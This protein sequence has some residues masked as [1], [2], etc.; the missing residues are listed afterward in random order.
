[1]YL[2]NEVKK[3]AKQ[4]GVTYFGIADLSIAS[5]TIKEQGGDIVS[6]YPYSISLGIPLLKDIVDQLPNR[7]QRA[8]AMNYRA[9][10]E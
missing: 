8:I 1:M 3:L 10:I 2:N 4:H 7:H 9:Q 6:K 5:D